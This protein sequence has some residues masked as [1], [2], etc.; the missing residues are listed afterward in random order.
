[1]FLKAMIL[2]YSVSLSASAGLNCASREIA[3]PTISNCLSTAEHQ[4]PPVVRE[5]PAGAEPVNQ[6]YGLLDI[7][8]VLARFKRHRPWIW[9]APGAA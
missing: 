9:F 3:S 7:E 8:Q 1:M 6:I 2:R 4:V 5:A